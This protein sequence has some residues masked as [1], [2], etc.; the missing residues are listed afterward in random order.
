MA[1]LNENELDQALTEVITKIDSGA[2]TC[3]DFN[4]LIVKSLI[5]E[6]TP[7]GVRDRIRRRM[8]R[9]ETDRHI[10]P[11]SGHQSL[12]LPTFAG[13]VQPKR[14][15]RHQQNHGRSRAAHDR[16]TR[17]QIIN[18]TLEFIAANQGKTITEEMLNRIAD[19]DL[20]QKCA[21]KLMTRP[22]VNRDWLQDLLNK[23]S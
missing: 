10:E 17:T 14:A 9:N 15:P 4:K 1:T 12:S 22:G 8:S 20:L 19:R 3:E 23:L 6:T 13:R 7:E 5:G 21:A 2:V 18:A 16:S 11:E